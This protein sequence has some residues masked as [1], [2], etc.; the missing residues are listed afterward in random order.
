LASRKAGIS[1]NE[2]PKTLQEAIEFTK[3]MGVRFL[4]ID[5]LC[6][7]QDDREDW[8]TE[9]A[10][11]ASIY[12]NAILTI[13][14][15]S[16]ASANGGCFMPRS[17]TFSIQTDLTDYSYSNIFVRQP[18]AMSHDCIIG[19]TDGSGAAFAQGIQDRYPG[20]VRGWIFQERLLSTRILHCAWDEMIWECP[21]STK[22]ECS[23]EGPIRDETPIGKEMFDLRSWE[24]PS[25]V[26]TYA[27]ILMQGSTDLHKTVYIRFWAELLESFTMRKFTYPEDR[28]AALSSIAKKF[29]GFGLGQYYAGIWEEQVLLQ[30]GWES[31]LETRLADD[32]CRIGQPSWS[33]ASLN[34]RCSWFI[35]YIDE[36][37][38]I[39]KVLG[40]ETELGSSEPTGQVRAGRLRLFTSTASAVIFFASDAFDKYTPRRSGALVWAKERNS[41]W[42]HMVYTDVGQTGQERSKDNDALNLD[43]LGDGVE[44]IIA[45][46]FTF[47]HRRDVGGGYG[48]SLV[49]RERPDKTYQ[50]VGMMQVVPSTDVDSARELII[51]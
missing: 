3:E 42:Q 6:I 37:Y 30:L 16:S 38:P 9:A 19:T 27:R 43:H 48:F 51:V 34:T 15:T 14:A 8:A 25:N 31:L 45:P 35:E 5:A 32:S 24:R 18:R 7:I 11:M 40:I 33:W 23:F 36:F 17:P 10:K 50:R 28:L 41:S 21:E 22:C 47:R 39:A 44:V 49:L 13:S 46:L 2:I 12:E 20:L 4:W 1:L 26:K 29:S